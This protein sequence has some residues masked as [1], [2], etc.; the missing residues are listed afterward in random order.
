M[1]ISQLSKEYSLG[2]LNRLA[3]GEFVILGEIEEVYNEDLLATIPANSPYIIDGQIV[4][5]KSVFTWW[6]HKVFTLNR[7]TYTLQFQAKGVNLASKLRTGGK[8]KLVEVKNGNYYII[9]K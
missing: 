3:K 1:K 9:D 5:S 8:E 2:K 7:I 4:I 6:L